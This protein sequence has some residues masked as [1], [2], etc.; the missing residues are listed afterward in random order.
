MRYIFADH[1]IP[2][3]L[4]VA[5]DARLAVMETRWG[6]VPDMAGIALL[7]GLVRDDLARELTYTARQVTGTEAV[8]LGL[9]THTADDPHAA[10]KYRVNGV[11]SNMPEFQKAFACKAGD[12]MV[13]PNACRVW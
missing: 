10:A 8:A 3:S 7:R 13:R 12:A 5:P 1:V 9:A 4:D 2:A 11:V 6:L